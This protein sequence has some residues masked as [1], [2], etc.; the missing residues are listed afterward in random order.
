[1][2]VTGQTCLSVRTSVS[3]CGPESVSPRRLWIPLPF[4][5]F[6]FEGLHLFFSCGRFHFVV[7]SSRLSFFFFCPSAHS[8]ITCFMSGSFKAVFH[9]HLSF[10]SYIILCHFISS[11]NSNIIAHK[12]K[13]KISPEQ[14]LTVAATLSLSDELHGNHFLGLFYLCRDILSCVETHNNQPAHVILQP[15]HLTAKL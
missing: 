1:M 7:L 14:R 3:P 12:K 2:L 13:K 5:L 11:C 8:Y 6:S 10:F 9:S 4:S 15:D